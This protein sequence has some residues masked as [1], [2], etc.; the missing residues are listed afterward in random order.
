MPH[1]PAAT[2]S[3]QRHGVM[4]TATH[5]R[6]VVV[7]HPALPGPN[8][9]AARADYVEAPP[10]SM[11]KH[12]PPGGI[13]GALGPFQSEHGAEAGEYEPGEND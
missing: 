12:S 6:N 9:M 7:R 5:P 4:R 8:M 10:G 3:H 2:S 13:T 11:S 1:I